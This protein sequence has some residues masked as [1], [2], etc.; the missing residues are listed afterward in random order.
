[1][2]DE[3]GKDAVHKF[4]E[5]KVARF[6]EFANKDRYLAAQTILDPLGTL[7]RHGLVEDADR[8]LHSEVTKGS[9]ADIAYFK[10][11]VAARGLDNVLTTP[12]EGVEARARI[13]VT[14][15]VTFT[16]DG[17]RVTVTVT[18]AL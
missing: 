1:M 16:W 2:A 10:E 13:V 18:F 11:A 4:R 7:A 17:V 15:S 8:E 12:T 9:L 3:K 6:Q 5:A 14:I